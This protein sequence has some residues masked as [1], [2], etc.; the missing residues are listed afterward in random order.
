MNYEPALVGPLEEH[1]LV[2]QSRGLDGGRDVGQ[3]Q[4]RNIV[5]IHPELPRESFGVL[6][7]VFFVTLVQITFKLGR[8]GVGRVH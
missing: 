7:V 5:K 2:L 3:L 6:F 1:H 4:I 8:Y